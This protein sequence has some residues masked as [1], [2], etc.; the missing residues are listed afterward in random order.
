MG[1]AMPSKPNDPR[2]DSERLC[3]RSLELRDR[4]LREIERSKTARERS[5]KMRKIVGPHRE[6]RA[7]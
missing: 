6:R 7:S 4:S 2:Q 3:A 1:G 5:Q